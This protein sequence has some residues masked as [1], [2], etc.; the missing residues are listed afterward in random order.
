M[1]TETEVGVEVDCNSDM[2][3]NGQ[4]F[5]PL[6]LVV[7]LAFLEAFYPRLEGSTNLIDNCI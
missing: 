3:S 7:F 4:W 1:N 5:S 2:T 6:S